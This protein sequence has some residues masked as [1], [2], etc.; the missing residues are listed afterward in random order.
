MANVG[1]ILVDRYRLDGRIGAG[2]FATVFRA[3]DLRLDR[4]VAVKVLSA[5]YLGDPV[6]VVRF[7]REARA[8]AAF[9]H[10][11]VV[12]IHDVEPAEPTLGA[13]TFL[14]MDL[15]EGGSLATRMAAVGSRGLAPDVLVPILIDVAAGLDALHAAGM[16]HRDVKP[17]NVL[18]LGGRALIADLGIAAAVPGEITG[19]GDA[20]GTLAYLAPEQLAGA[21]ATPASDVHALGV[22]AYLGLT[23]RLPRASEQH[24]RARRGF[25]HGS[26]TGL[27][28]RRWPW[29]DVRS[30][31]GD[32]A[33]SRPQG[34]SDRPAVRLAA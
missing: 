15:C 4:E 34:S 24:R 23:G 16:V 8:L 13:E 1:D 26:T 32:R 5:N 9:S 12:A 25:S 10:P 30:A 7:D 19:S 6:V 28:A 17:S 20:M 33:R 11:N 29:D 3:R 14:V 22:V 21:Q 2:G 18:L 27:I 31:G